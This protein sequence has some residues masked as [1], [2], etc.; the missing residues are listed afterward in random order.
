LLD[1]A[2][3][4]LRY[5]YGDVVE[6]WDEEKMLRVWAEFW[7]VKKIYGEVKEQ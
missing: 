4:I 1:R 5:E 7:F 3:A 6:N 2:T